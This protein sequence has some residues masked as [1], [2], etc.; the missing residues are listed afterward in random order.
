MLCWGKVADKKEIVHILLR[1]GQKSKKLKYWKYVFTLF[2]K[3]LD[4]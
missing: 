4:E 3:S 2:D 1:E